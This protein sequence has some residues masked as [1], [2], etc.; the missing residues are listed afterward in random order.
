MPLL[1][2]LLLLQARWLLP[3]SGT[4]SLDGPWRVHAGDSA[5][6]ASPAFSDSAWGTVAVPDAWS[7]RGAARPR[8]WIW[9]RARLELDRAPE[10]ELGLQVHASGVAFAV[11]VDGQAVGGVGGFPPDYAARTNVPASFALPIASLA[12]G[13]HLIA[14]RVYSAESGPVAVGPVIVAPLATLDARERSGDAYMLAAAALFVGLA[15]YQLVFWVRRRE[16]MEH[17]YVF[18]F[19]LGLTLYFVNWMPSVQ[20]GLAR[21]MDW[22]R[23]Y[24]AFSAAAIMA[25]ALGARSLFEVESDSPLGRAAA[26][27][28]ALFGLVVPLALLL[29]EW[30]MV[31]WTERFPYNGG[32][33]VAGA[34]L[35]ALAA[36]GRGRGVRAAT[37]L[38][39]GSVFLVLTVVHDVALSWGMLPRWGGGSI[40]VQYG[41]VVFVFSVAFTTAAKFAET[42]TTALY[43]RLTGLY[44]REIVM[45]AL[46]R[47]IRRALRIHQPVAVIMLDVDRFKSVNDTL[48]HPA[49]DKVLTEVGRRL[50]DAGRAV[51]W[52]GRY[53]GDEFIAVLAATGKAGGVQAAERFRAA[54]A[55]LPIE[56]GRAS[57]TLALS[58]GVAAYDAGEEWPTAEQLVGAADAAL[59]RAKDSG[60]NRTCE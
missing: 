12:P 1:F 10:R 32:I 7:E 48:G 25:L 14:L 31:R 6:Y 50:A 35:I 41:A 8:G 17:L 46:A 59:Y 57:R 11:F 58:A 20:V 56:V 15:A 13:S 49:G 51:D 53:G 42:Q 2:A 44:R 30:S 5:A 16:A 40:T 37:G 34:V 18:L 24:L 29:P 9:Y 26:A 3:P 4:V 27:L 47:E 33:L 45:D 52:L 55:A 54:V 23:L 39:W 19:C 22:F 43:D 38:F 28:A 21:V 36:S 60:R